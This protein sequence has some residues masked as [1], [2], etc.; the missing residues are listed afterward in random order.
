[1]KTRMNKFFIPIFI[2]LVCVTA[3]VDDYTESNDPGLLDAPALR[4]GASGTNE[5][6]VSTPV[7]QYQNVQSAYVLYGTPA[8]FTVSVIDAPGKVGAI[9]VEP[10]VPEFGTVTIDEASVAALQGKENGSFNFTFTPNPDLTP[11]EERALNLVVTVSDVQT[12]ADGEAAPKT[13]QVAIG[14]TLVDG[15]C[16]TTGIAEGLYMVTDATGT[17]DGGDAYTLD[18]LKL[19]GGVNN[20]FV[21]VSQERPGVYQIDEVTGGVWP[22]FYSGRA[23]PALLVDVC[24]S[25]I[26]GRPGSVTAGSEGGPL[27]TFTING[28]INADNSITITWSYIREDAP[29]PADPAHGSYTMKPF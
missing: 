29:T 2:I 15:P 13:T 14:T 27:R 4:L 9:S 12:N 22:A 17:T 7:N 19:Y 11:D 20:V 25:T 5:I 16:L 24:G 10:S 8:T 18:S 23:N 1:M 21:E 3:C 26:T 28:V 6:V